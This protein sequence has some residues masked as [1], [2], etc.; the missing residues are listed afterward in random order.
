MRESVVEIQR[1]LLSQSFSNR[2]RSGVVGRVTNAAECCQGTILRIEEEV[3]ADG[4]INHILSVGP[5]VT[6]KALR[7]GIHRLR[8]VQRFV[9]T[10]LGW[11]GAAGISKIKI[12]G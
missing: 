2:Y 4:R 11:I 8:L 10:K 7:N 1:Q 6:I 5:V 3:P 12:V 9:D